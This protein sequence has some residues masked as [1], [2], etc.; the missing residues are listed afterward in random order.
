MKEIEAGFLGEFDFTNSGKLDMSVPLFDMLYDEEGITKKDENVIRGFHNMLCDGKEVLDAV[1]DFD[2]DIVRLT[3]SENDYRICPRCELGYS[4]DS[5]IS[6]DGV[7]EIC[8]RCHEYEILNEEE[9]EDRRSEDRN[10]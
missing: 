6:K 1:Y 7:T 3:L 2:E 5:I 8:P 9:D 10:N 4:E